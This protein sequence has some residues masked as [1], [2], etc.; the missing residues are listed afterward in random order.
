MD[1]VNMFGGGGFGDGI[2]PEVLFQMMN[3]GGGFGGGGGKE[4]GRG[5]KRPR[6]S[7]PEPEQPT[8]EEAEISQRPAPE[9][10]CGP[11]VANKW[12][13][14]D[15]IGKEWWKQLCIFERYDLSRAL[16]PVDTY[17]AT[18]SHFEIRY[19]IVEKYEPTHPTDRV[20]LWIKECLNVIRPGARIY[21]NSLEVS[22][23]KENDQALFEFVHNLVVQRG[24]C[25]VRPSVG[26]KVVA[27]QQ[28]HRWG[29]KTDDLDGI[30]EK[31]V[32]ITVY[33][34]GFQ[35]SMSQGTY[36]YRDQKAKASGL[37]P[38]RNSTFTL[39]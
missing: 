7:T 32:F 10:D 19:R 8:F 38:E 28:W 15:C 20:D 37:V 12:A 4:Q 2:D 36:E 16:I 14:R 3:G 17:D 13:E 25:K 9:C 11:H 21:E 31:D 34:R 6:I 30:S 5:E 33:L 22:E 26:C 24:E 18:P 29:V 1:P 27:L 39:P 35:D 23:I